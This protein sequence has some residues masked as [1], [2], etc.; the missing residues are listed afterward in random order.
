[1]LRVRLSLPSR[2]WGSRAVLGEREH[3]LCF[4]PRPRAPH[5]GHWGLGR[6]CLPAGWSPGEKPFP[7]GGHSCSARCRPHP[8][9]Q[10]PIPTL[11]A[12]ELWRNRDAP[13]T[14]LPPPLPSPLYPPLTPDL[15]WPLPSSLPEFHHLDPICSA[16]GGAHAH[17]G[18]IPGEDLH[19]GRPLE[20]VGAGLMGCLQGKEDSKAVTQGREQVRAESP[21]P[22]DQ[23]GR[24][25]GRLGAKSCRW[26][27]RDT[28]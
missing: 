18:G 14:P 10:P 19:L 20:H 25:L 27:G 5:R 13:H 2:T 24:L 7:G 21:D 1:M 16:L 17:Q 15:T 23:D 9:P 6:Q 8:Q 11:E 4:D 12:T 3:T 28:R 22:R 26:Q